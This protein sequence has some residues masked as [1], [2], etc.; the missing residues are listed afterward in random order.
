MTVYRV[1][2][3]HDSGLVSVLTPSADAE[4]AAV[5]ACRV[6]CAPLRSVVNVEAVCSF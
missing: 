5:T 4:S 6:E 2:L 1:T 3:R